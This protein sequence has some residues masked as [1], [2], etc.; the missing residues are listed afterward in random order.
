MKLLYLNR[1]LSTMKIV[2][3]LLLVFLSLG[4]QASPLPSKPHI[5]V[6]GSATIEAEPD[7]MSFSIMITQTESTLAQAKLSVDTRSNTLIELCKKLGIPNENIA[8][9]TLRVRPSYTYKD[10]KRVPNGTIVSRNVDIHLKDLDKYSSVMMAF[11]DSEISQII[12]TK[13]LV[14]NES[15]LTDDA[16]VKALADAKRR[17]ERLAIAQGRK[18][19]NAFSISEFMTRGEE[20]YMLHVSRKVVGRSSSVMRAEMPME[21]EPFEPGVMVAK[22]QVYVVYLLK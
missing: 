21:P 11:V 1:K 17:A 15:S 7:E 13:L 9:T 2:T 22:A 6:E 18:L 4:L 20:R 12:S 8:T 10:N 19:G 3:V 16:L 14:S 5:Y